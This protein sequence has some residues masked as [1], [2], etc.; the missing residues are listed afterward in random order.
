MS[1][2]TWTTPPGWSIS[3][4]E[5]RCRSSTCCWP[6]GTWTVHK[7]SHRRLWLTHSSPR[8]STRPCPP[9]SSSMG[10]GE[11]ETLRGLQ[12]WV[13]SCLWTDFY[14]C[15]FVCAFL[16]GLKWMGLVHQS[17]SVDVLFSHCQSDLNKSHPHRHR[18]AQF[19]RGNF[20]CSLFNHK[21]W[22]FETKI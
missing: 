10:T 9:R 5:S 21:Y 18:L 4:R 2:L 15:V 6:G 3:S 13:L 14:I 8:T 1:V 12:G 11:E 17:E 20:N 7:C 16:T 22:M 19:V